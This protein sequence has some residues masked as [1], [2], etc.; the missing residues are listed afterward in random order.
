MSEA[1]PKNQDGRS[2]GSHQYRHA[3]EPESVF[4]RISAPTRRRHARSAIYAPAS[5]RRE[6]QLP[7]PAEHQLI[8]LSVLILASY[9]ADKRLAKSALRQ[10][11]KP[12]CWI[13]YGAFWHD[14]LLFEHL[15]LFG[16]FYNETHLNSLR[17]VSLNVSMRNRLLILSLFAVV[18]GLSIAFAWMYAIKDAKPSSGTIAS[19]SEIIDE[20][21]CAECHSEQVDDYRSS[22]H[23]STFYLTKESDIAR[24]LD[25]QTFHDPDRPYSYSYH[26]DEET[27]L[28]VSIPKQF[29]DERLQLPYLLGSGNNAITFLSLVPDR[30]GDTI[31][32]EHRVTLYAKDGDSNEDGWDLDLTP[33]QQRH[34]PQR[35]VEH[36][37]MVMRGDKLT[38]CIGCHT[39]KARISRQQI[40]ELHA[41]VGCQSCHGPGNKHVAAMTNDT[42]DSYAGFSQQSAQAE[43]DMCG[44]C[45]RRAHSDASETESPNDIRIVRFQSV[46]LARSRCF[47]QSEGQLRCTT[48]HDPHKTVSRD[49]M[50]YVKQ[51]MN[52]HVAGKTTS[53]PVSPQANCVECHMPP[54]DVHRGIEFHDH[55]IR[56]RASTSAKP[57]VGADAE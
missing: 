7:N 41:H 10:L 31:G 44:R 27:G 46:G 1:T 9:F 45:H 38:Q 51:C 52:C 12:K 3:E 16:T 4:S 33:G 54:I 5:Q 57:P 21:T 42:A 43:V 14:S 55:W 23:S 15:L 11:N 34:L 56:V 39:T 8:L 30:L 17:R 48:C 50:H 47:T 28:S 26:F 22:G 37:G 36:F 20:A 25:G 18:I 19:T 49:K 32:I 53:C 6:R 24:W 40:E 13:D 2:L 35:Q 29:G